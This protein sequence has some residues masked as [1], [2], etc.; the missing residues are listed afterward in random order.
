MDNAIQPL[1]PIGEIELRLGY[2]R[3]TILGWEQSGLIKEGVH[4]A[5]PGGGHRRYSV[6]A[7]KDFVMNTSRDVLDRE[8]EKSNLLHAIVLNA[9]PIVLIDELRE[10]NQ[11]AVPAVLIDAARKI[12]KVKRHG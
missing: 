8:A 7:M 5:R 12:L 2:N 6:P 4:F 10:N 11:Y 1:V 3:S 9:Q